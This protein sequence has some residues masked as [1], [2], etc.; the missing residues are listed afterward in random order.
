[1][2]RVKG[3]MRKKNTDSDYIT[4]T[5]TEDGAWKFTPKMKERYRMTVKYTVGR[6]PL[7][8]SKEAIEAELKRMGLDSWFTGEEPVVPDSKKL[9]IHNV[10]RAFNRY[11]AYTSDDAKA[12]AKTL[13]S[14][15]KDQM[16]YLAEVVLA[17]AGVAPQEAIARAEELAGALIDR[18]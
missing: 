14:Y 17:Y 9:Y 7:A 18:I 5:I 11:A 10:H 13:A 2:V 16:A 15:D 12:L 1:M 6:E 8:T 4:M 3:G